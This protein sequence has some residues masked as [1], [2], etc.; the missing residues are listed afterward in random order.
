MAY[1][2]MDDLGQQ[3]QPGTPENLMTRPE[4]DRLRELEAAGVPHGQ[5][6]Q[7][8]YDARSAGRLPD[9]P[10]STL[11][12]RI[13]AAPVLFAVAAGA[14]GLAIGLGAMWLSSRKSETKRQ[15]SAEDAA[16]RAAMGLPDL[17]DAPTGV[18]LRNG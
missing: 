3:A 10:A 18:L 5:A 11:R 17:S 7:M 13:A 9:V 16:I 14:A 12:Q 2:Y 6:K 15:R 4:Y 8:I 1:V